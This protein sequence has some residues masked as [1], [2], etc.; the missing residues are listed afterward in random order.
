MKGEG[1]GTGWRAEAPEKGEKM[2][3]S[4]TGKTGLGLLLEGQQAWVWVG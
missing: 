2:G 3:C 4:L 1:R